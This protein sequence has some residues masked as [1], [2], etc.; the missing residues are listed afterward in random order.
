MRFQLEAFC[1]EFSELSDTAY[2]LEIRSVPRLQIAS[3]K[4]GDVTI[5]DLRGKST[6]NGGESELLSSYLQTLVA[7][8][9]R[10]MLLN[11]ADLT[12]LDSN[13]VSVIV[14]TFALLRKKGSDLRLLR[15]GGAVLDVFKVL[16]LLE[17]IPSFED[18]TQALASFYV[19]E[20]GAI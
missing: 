1:S 16:H 14:R 17:I 12:Q 11:L 5:V 10:K 15:P 19:L 7:S 8:G 9:V 3:R 18:E 2:E 4:C 20:G 6:P 13:G